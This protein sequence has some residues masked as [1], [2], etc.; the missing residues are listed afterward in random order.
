MS[1]AS[2]VRSTKPAGR[3]NASFL[4]CPSDRRG[5]GRKDRCQPPAAHWESADLPAE[6]DAGAAIR[7]AAKRL[8]PMTPL[9]ADRL[10]PLGEEPGSGSGQIATP[11]DPVGENKYPPKVSQ[12]RAFGCRKGRQKVQLCSK[13][14]SMRTCSLI[15]RS[16]ARENESPLRYRNC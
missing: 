5:P 12:G 13:G 8:S 7:A 2:T 4:C 9:A 14:S 1:D 16:Q 11:I 15:T 3:L 10:P 6:Q